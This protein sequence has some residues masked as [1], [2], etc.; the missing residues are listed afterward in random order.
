MPFTFVH[1]AIILPLKKG[2]PRWF[3]MTGLIVGSLAPDFEYFIRMKI[4]SIYSHTILG[5]FTFNLPVGICLAFIFHLI[6]KKDLIENLPTSWQRKLPALKELDWSTYFKKN[7][8]IVCISIL[9]G[10][11][12]H[13]FW[14]AFTHRDVYFVE[15]L[16]LKRTVTTYYIPIYKILQHLSTLVGGLLIMTYFFRM[17]TKASTTKK[18]SLKYWVSLAIL[19]IMILII[20]LVFGLNIYEYGNVIVSGI[21]AIMVSMVVF[22]FLKNKNERL[23]IKARLMK[24]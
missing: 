11:S 23:K 20:R 22:S 2:F 19:T 13:I 1:P 16:D 17:P 5:T 7:W 9:I 12:S 3:S 14:D 4:Q 21:T 18:P 15:L 6:V 8:L 10:A 24:H